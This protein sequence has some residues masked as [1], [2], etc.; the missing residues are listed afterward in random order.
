MT[1]CIVGLMAVVVLLNNCPICLAGSGRVDLKEYL[2]ELPE[3]LHAQVKRLDAFVDIKFQ[4]LSAVDR[5]DLKHAGLLNLLERHELSPNEWSKPHFLVSSDVRKICRDHS[6][7]R[8]FEEFRPLILSEWDT[9]EPADLVLEMEPKLRES[10]LKRLA[11]ID[12]SDPEKFG[13]VLAYIALV[14]TNGLE[15]PEG[16]LSRFAS[17]YPNATRH[18]ID[19][20]KET[21][22]SLFRRAR[23][24]IKGELAWIV[25]AIGVAFVAL[26][27]LCIARAS[28]TEAQD[29]TSGSPSSSEY[30]QKQAT[31]LTATDLSSKHWAD[32]EVAHSSANEHAYAYVTTSHRR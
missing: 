24:Y 22:N 16:F 7:L 12:L 8:S 27:I 30:I 20:L 17:E 11:A 14:R 21:R 4:W 9:E 15:T 10:Y 1:K 18:A 3:K 31:E 19:C 26:G 6:R 29:T 23:Y 32:Y 13:T 28:L 2:S 25:T 5:D